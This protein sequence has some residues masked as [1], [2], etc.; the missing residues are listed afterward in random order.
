M[1]YRLLKEVAYYKDEVLTNENKL[2]DMKRDTTKDMYDVKRHEQILNESYMMVPDSSKR[3][4]FAMD[5]LSLFFSNHQTILD[6]TGPWY[7]TAQ[8]LLHPQNTNPLY[9]HENKEVE[10]RT[11]SG[12]V[13]TNVDD[14]LDGEAF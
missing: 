13:E 6:P 9:S 3:L 12:V 10:N 8:Q 1:C 14:I 5:E 7:L 2:D 11:S 4:Q